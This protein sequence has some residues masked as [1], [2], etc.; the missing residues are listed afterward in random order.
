MGCVVDTIGSAVSWGVELMSTAGTGAGA[1]AGASGD[2]GVSSSGAVSARYSFDVCSETD[3]LG[4]QLTVPKSYSS[5]LSLFRCSPS[6][7]KRCN[8]FL[9]AA[10]DRAPCIGDGCVGVRRGLASV[11]SLRSCFSR[12]SS[13]SD[14]PSSILSSRRVYCLARYDH[15]T[16]CIR[17]SI[18]SWFGNT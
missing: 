8:A 6:D 15:D 17:Y 4:L 9:R 11:A 3:S 7:Q 2:A 1:G 13:V 10:F 5:S 14:A 16:Y 18:C 12:S